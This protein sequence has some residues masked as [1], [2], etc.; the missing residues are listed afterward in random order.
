MR[1]LILLVGCH[2]AAPCARIDAQNPLVMAATQIRIEVYGDV[3]C[4]G[5]RPASGTPQLAK[6]F[7]KG[8][9]I[10]VDVGAGAH[11][12]ALYTIDASGRETGSAC[13]R[14]NWGAGSTVCVNLPIL[15][16]DDLAAPDSAD[17][18]GDCVA[19]RECQANQKLEYPAGMCVA[20]SCSYPAPK[21]T[22]C[23]QG[24]YGGDCTGGLS[25]VDPAQAF[26]A[27]TST[28]VALTEVSGAGSGGGTA[29][30]SS[31]VEVRVAFSPR[32]TGRAVT[33]KYSLDP[34]F[35]A[36]TSL[37]LGFSSYQGSDREV[38]SATI[39]AQPSGSKVYFFVEVDGY[40]NTILFAPG[41]GK[42]YE[43]GS[44]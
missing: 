11:T 10:A 28:S 18:G 21:S 36:Q 12:I 8:Q 34:N 2:A 37:P 33:L 29:P 31:G 17:A 14:G 24:C 32:G 9:E 7:D 13:A 5:A 27:G 16:L 26:V 30:S 42:N 41:G 44:Q 35:T 43:Y 1:W 23:P 22:I 38:W 25:A 4:E 6:S 20:D 15:S 40:D 39:P 19:K 3:G